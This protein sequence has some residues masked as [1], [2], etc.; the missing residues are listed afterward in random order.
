MCLLDKKERMILMADS[1]AGVVYKLNVRTGEYEVVFDVLELKP[2]ESARPA[3]GINGVHVV[4]GVLYFA[5]T[6]QGLLGSVPINNV[7]K[8]MGPMKVISEEVPAAD[9]FVVDARDGSVWLAE[10]VR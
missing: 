5:S 8:P 3:S 4:D 10:N 6:N 1:P 7:G 9:D 2:V